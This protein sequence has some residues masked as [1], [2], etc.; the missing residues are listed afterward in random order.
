M[1]TTL[2]TENTLL[3]H[4]RLDVEGRWGKPDVKYK[5]EGVWQDRVK[6]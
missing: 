6:E 4:R 2:I 5:S 3:L 1:E